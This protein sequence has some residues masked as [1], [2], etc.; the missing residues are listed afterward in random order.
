MNEPVKYYGCR[1]VCSYE[2]DMPLSSSE[3][4]FGTEE[5][6]TEF[7]SEY[8]KEDIDVDTSEHEYGWEFFEG[9]L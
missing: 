7:L 1:Y 8:D 3:Y 6:R 5:E 4:I 2:D 9:E